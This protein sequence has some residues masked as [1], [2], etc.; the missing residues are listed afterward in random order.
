MLLLESSFSIE[1]TSMGALIGA[2][3]GQFIILSIGYFKK[4]ND[5]KNK[6]K[7]IISDIKTQ[8]IILNSVKSKYKLLKENFE[9][10]NT[11]KFETS[12]YQNLHLDIYQSVPKDEL[13]LIFKDKLHILVDIYKTIEFIKM[14]SPEKIYDNYINASDAHLENEKNNPNHE[15]YCEHEMGLIQ[16]AINNLI[17]NIKTIDSLKIDIDKLIS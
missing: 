12:V 13:F 11:E 15:R 3:I 16:F 6:K 7:M 2:L 14:H 9:N 4:K 10:K 17:N 5:L 1:N 8:M